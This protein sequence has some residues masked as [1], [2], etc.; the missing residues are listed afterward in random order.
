[1]VILSPSRTNSSDV[2]RFRISEIAAVIGDGSAVEYVHDVQVP[3]RTRHVPVFRKRLLP[4][5]TQ[6]PG[7]MTTWHPGCCGPVTPAAS[8]PDADA[9]GPRADMKP[10]AE[11]E[12]SSIVIIRKKKSVSSFDITSFIFLVP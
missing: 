2:V 5:G 8:S 6:V 3:D 7:P 4:W 10:R 1:M 11:A 12:T 9:A